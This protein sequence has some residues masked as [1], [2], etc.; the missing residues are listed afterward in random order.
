[1]AGGDGGGEG[2]RRWA[3]GVFGLWGWEPSP[4]LVDPRVSLPEDGLA[5]RSL[6][7]A[8]IDRGERRK[9][10]TIPLGHGLARRYRAGSEIHT[11][12]RWISY[13]GRDPPSWIEELM[14]SGSKDPGRSRSKGIKIRV[15]Q[16]LKGSRSRR[17][18]IPADRGQRMKPP[19]TKVGAPVKVISMS[20]LLLPVLLN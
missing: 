6:G 13:Q 2:T 4:F 5:A 12:N 17:S 14:G 16:V 20:A 7:Q 11:K 9:G 18:S 8:G 19:A 3:L 10:L 1:M 15:D